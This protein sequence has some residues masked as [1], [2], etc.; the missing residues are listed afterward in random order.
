MSAL[1]MVAL[2][3]GLGFILAIGFFSVTRELYLRTEYP[4]LL[5]PDDDDDKEYEDATITAALSSNQR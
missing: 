3:V 5:S 1:I 4:P 2:F